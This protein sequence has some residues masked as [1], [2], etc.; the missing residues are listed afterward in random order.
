MEKNK[1]G[2]NLALAK[3]L[4][5]LQDCLSHVHHLVQVGITNPLVFM[6]LVLIVFVSVL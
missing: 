5:P 4:D 6:F 2:T 3:V 1:R